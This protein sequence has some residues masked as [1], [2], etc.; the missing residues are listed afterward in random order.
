MRKPTNGARPIPDDEPGSERRRSEG[1][2]ALM[3]VGVVIG[4]QGRNARI[5]AGQ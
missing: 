4:E 2:I 3:I 5:P 1:S